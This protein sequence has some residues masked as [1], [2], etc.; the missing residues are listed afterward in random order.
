MIRL[1]STRTHTMFATVWVL[2]SL[3]C[4][5]WLIGNIT[6]L[7]SPESWVAQN[8]M[9]NAPKQGW[10]NEILVYFHI[11]MIAS[12]IFPILFCFITL[13]GLIRKRIFSLFTGYV[14]LA[15]G[16]FTNLIFNVVVI[17]RGIVDLY[18]IFKSGLVLI[19]ELMALILLIK[20]TIEF[21]KKVKIA[22]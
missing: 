1:P 10:S 17:R 2:F 11:S 8:N 7:I 15:T 13:F 5:A 19:I 21:F 12:I 22:E 18:F 3:L 16:L 14:S 6:A 4:L 20:Y 9:P